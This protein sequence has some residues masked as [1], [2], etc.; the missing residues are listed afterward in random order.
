MK[1]TP[2]DIATFTFCPIL[3]YKGK[4]SRYFPR[5][6]MYEECMK[7]AFVKAEEDAILKDTIVSTKRLTSAWDKIWWPKAAANGIKMSDSEK[8][9]LKAAKRFIEYC[10]YEITDHLWPSI[11]T[12]VLSEVRI[13]SSVLS[14]RANIIKVDLENKKRNTVIVDF[15]NRDL[16]VRDAAFDT[17]IKCTL[18]PFY[19]GRGE[20]MIYINVNISEAKE[21]LSTRFAKFTSEDM[22]DIGKMISYAEEGIRR[23]IKYMNS[24]SCK[25]CKVCPEFK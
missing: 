20:D 9:T 11:G 7:E 17:Y 3:Y 13:G 15:T 19:S 16:S 10:K 8:I 22:H 1:L 2:I 25:D 14:S 18:Y 5:M 4:S 6:N 21:K 24:F 23:R 12:D